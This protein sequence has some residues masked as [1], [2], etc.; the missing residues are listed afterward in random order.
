MMRARVVCAFV[1]LTWAGAV[2]AQERLLGSATATTTPTFTLWNFGSGA[3]QPDPLGGE[4]VRVT[5]VW[6]LNLPFAA[7][8]PV[9]RWLTIDA[10]GA[11]ERGEV[12]LG[13]TDT[14]LHATRY[15]LNGLTDIKV[16]AVIHLVEDHVLLSLGANAPSG[17]TS[18]SVEQLKALRIIAAPGLELPTSTLGIG[19]GGTAGLVLAARTGN[20]AWAV[21]SSYEVRGSYTPYET[22]IATVQSPSYQ[23]GNT[24][25]FDV[26]ADGY[27]GQSNMTFDVG[28]DVY[29]HDALNSPQTGG[30]VFRA[31]VELG[32]A[33]RGS[34]SWRFTPGGFH[35][36]T[37]YAL[38]R[39][40]SKY[41]QNDVSV[42]GTSGNYLDAGLRSIIAL[43]TTTGWVLD[44]G[45]VD[46]T[47]L[48]V[49]HSFAAAGMLGGGLTIG[50]AQTIGHFSL[51]P[52]LRGQVGR[53]DLGPSH[54]IATG[55][56]IG[57]SLRVRS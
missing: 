26:G 5:R 35:D 13:T 15:T 57:L 53:L 12:D 37:L 25:R 50:I 41:S 6:E 48:A 10:S 52:F 47:G 24:L 31:N 43:G 22:F 8:V 46:Q 30:S 20:W 28:A 40:R 29:A 36:I 42:P 45:F 18:L 27:I 4:S 23:P 14:A 9:G 32:P 7:V 33:F 16:R 55:G 3:V 1:T 38:D 51:E 19:L 2:H 44:L 21:G 54:P 49:D 56:S 39:Y 11:Y 34:W 17:T